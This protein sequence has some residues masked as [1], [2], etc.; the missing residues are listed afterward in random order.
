[1]GEDHYLHLGLIALLLPRAKVIHCRRDAQ[2]AA[3]VQLLPAV[4]GGSLLTGWK[5]ESLPCYA[6]EA[7]N[8]FR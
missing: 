7:F 5:R 3:F 4:L 1:M 8:A 2:D 6:G